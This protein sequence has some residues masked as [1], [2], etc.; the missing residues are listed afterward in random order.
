[1]AFRHRLV[2]EQDES[3]CRELMRAMAKSTTAWVPTLQVLRMAARADDAVFRADERLRYIPWLIKHGMWYAD[4]DRAAA[5]AK[6]GPY[7]ESDKMMYQL[8]QSQVAQAHAAGVEL[9]IGTDAGDTY[10]FPGFSV[11]D[12]LAEFVAA[13]ISPAATL[14]IATLGAARYAGA[15]QDFGS[16]EV[17]KVADILLLD[18]NPLVDI[19]ATRR[20]QGMLFDGQFY[21]REGLDQLMQ[22]GAAQASSLQF[23]LQLLWRM[24]NSPIV[25]VQLAD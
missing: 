11:H 5:S 18:S 4:A 9:L 6:T 25:R 22:F 14:K 16:I 13:G 10:V 17:G 8:A 12:E 23:N 2:N 1:M 7:R 15:A 21:N 20:I 3:R 19:S 24:L